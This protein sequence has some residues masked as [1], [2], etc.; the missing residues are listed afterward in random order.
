MLLL[1][2][3]KL[4]SE[5]HVELKSKLVDPAHNC[6]YAIAVSESICIL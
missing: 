2:V 3:S 1:I 4:W 6:K 5:V